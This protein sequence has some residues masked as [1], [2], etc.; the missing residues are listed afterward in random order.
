MQALVEGR[1]TSQTGIHPEIQ[2]ASLSPKNS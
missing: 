2:M 1:I